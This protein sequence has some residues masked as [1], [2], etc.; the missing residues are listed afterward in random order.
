MNSVSNS[1]NPNLLANSIKD[2]RQI[3]SKFRPLLLLIGKLL[4]KNGKGS[5][6]LTKRTGTNAQIKHVKIL[7]RRDESIFFCNNFYYF[8]NKK[9]TNMFGSRIKAYTT[10]SSGL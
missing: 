3:D 7:Y 1:V 2:Y 4:S 5:W 9:S 6:A 8:H 10:V